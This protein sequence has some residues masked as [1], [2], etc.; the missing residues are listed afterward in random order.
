MTIEYFIFLIHPGKN[1]VV[2][3]VK[4][5]MIGW[6]RTLNFTDLSRFF[7]RLLPNENSDQKKL[8]KLCW[9][10]EDKPEDGICSWNHGNGEDLYYYT[11]EE[12]ENFEDLTQNLFQFL[13]FLYD[14]YLDKQYECQDEYGC[15]MAFK[16]ILIF[17]RVPSVFENTSAIED[18]K[19]ELKLG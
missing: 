7:L 13:I 14:T 3:R 9:I 16:D 18:D 2:D 6:N 17:M 8:V 19:K 11:K 10:D 4:R 15:A 12:I 5:C 1:G